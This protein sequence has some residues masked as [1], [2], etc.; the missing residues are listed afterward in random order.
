MEI[1]DVAT[2]LDRVATRLTDPHTRF[3]PLGPGSGA[4]GAGSS[5]ECGAVGRALAGLC[6]AALAARDRETARAAVAATTLATALRASVAG[7][8]DADAGTQHRVRG[9]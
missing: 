7:Y 6:A 3:E 9:A 1:H 2:R 5:G 8:R 4:F